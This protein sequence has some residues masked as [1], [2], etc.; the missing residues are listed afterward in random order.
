MGA[1]GV[2]WP[3]PTFRCWLLESGFPLAGI[4]ITPVN[5]AGRL[6]PRL[7]PSRKPR[8]WACASRVQVWFFRFHG[9][10]IGHILT[11]GY[12]VGI[13]CMA[14]DDYALPAAGH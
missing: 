7:L 14:R 1:T 9:Q 4:W 10:P 12:G 3:R 6:V 2:P 5:A 11:H 8:S 13:G